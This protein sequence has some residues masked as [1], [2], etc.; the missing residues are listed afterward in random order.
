M[1]S[2]GFP[3][4]KQKGST[5]LRAAIVFLIVAIIAAIFGFGG[6][7]GEATDFA[8]ILFFVFLIVFVVSLLL[9][10]RGSAAV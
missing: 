1:R 3:C 7:A 6:I 10:R 5:M 9:G 4:I 8:R 2:V